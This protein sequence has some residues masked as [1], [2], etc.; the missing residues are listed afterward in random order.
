M[1]INTQQAFDECVMGD[2]E[3][4]LVYGDRE[5][6]YPISRGSDPH[7]RVL[8]FEGVASFFVLSTEERKSLRR[9]WRSDIHLCLR[10]ED[11]KPR[12]PKPTIE[13]VYS[14]TPASIRASHRHLVDR[15]SELAQERI[16]KVFM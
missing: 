9:F 14:L 10:S 12:E 2:W 15:T 3:I 13:Q 4:G 11:D 6:T 7:H 1:K 5:A 8:S 16:N